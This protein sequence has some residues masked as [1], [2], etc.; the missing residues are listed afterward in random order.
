MRAPTL[1]IVG[2]RDLPVI[3]LNRAAMMHLACELELVIVPGA[4]HLFEEPGTLAAVVDHA[5]R[6]F[7][8]HFEADR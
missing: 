1:L 7:L 5:A 6:W 2:G 8:G 4:H 3:E